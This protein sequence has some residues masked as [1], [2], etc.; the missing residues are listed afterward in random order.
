MPVRLRTSGKD[1]I[2]SGTAITFHNDNLEVHIAQFVFIFN[3][4]NEGTEQKINFRSEGPTR[5]VIELFNFNSSLGT[6]SSSPVKLGTLVNRELFLTFV[7][8]SFSPSA[9]KVVHYTF[10]LGE[11][12]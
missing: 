4:I 9:S 2:A 12:A 10:M 8:T 6:G 11:P 7:V 1:I 5:L 3:F